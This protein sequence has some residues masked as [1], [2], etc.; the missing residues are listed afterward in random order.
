[1]KSKEFFIYPKYKLTNEAQNFD[2]CLVKTPIDEFGMH[3]DLSRE[4]D[5]IPCFPDQINLKEVI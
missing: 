3:E 5:R 2:I 4:F 1:M